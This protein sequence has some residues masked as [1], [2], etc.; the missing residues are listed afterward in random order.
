MDENTILK[1]A[2]ANLFLG[3]I[4]IEIEQARPVRITHTLSWW[5][6]AYISWLLGSIISVPAIFVYLG[7]FK[8]A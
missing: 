7:Y 1:Y 4:A 5:R 6:I 3:F 2:I 8:G